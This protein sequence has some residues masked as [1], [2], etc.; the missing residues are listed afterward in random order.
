V[1]WL[2]GA[3]TLL[4]ALSP[5]ITARLALA[6]HA[7]RT[8]RWVLIG[9]VFLTSM[10]GGHFGAGFG[11]IL[12]AVMAITLPYGIHQLQGLRN[13]LTLMINSVAALIFI[14]RGHLAL[15]AVYM[16]LVGTLIGGWLG[17]LLIRRLSPTFV[18]VLIVTIGLATTVRLAL[19]K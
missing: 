17:T 10:Y 4:F 8:R 5:W 14:I 19:V 11:I 13:V 18:R 3:A 6:E 7:H 2:I 12:L 1:P 15:D 16:I 9:G